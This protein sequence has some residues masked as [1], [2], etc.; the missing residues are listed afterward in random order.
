M[1]QVKTAVAV[2]NLSKK[3]KGFTLDI[4]C[5]KIPQGFATALIGENGAGK[6][7]LLNA[8]A[9]VRL[10]YKGNMEFFGQ[11]DDK[12][13]ENADCPVKEM[14]GYVGS[15]NYYLPQWTVKQVEEI[16][17]LLYQNFDCNKFENYIQQLQVATKDN[18]GKGKKVNDLSDGNRMKL[19][20]SGA[21]C[22]R[23]TDAD[24]GRTGI[25]AGSF[26]A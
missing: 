17:D 3:F 15:N 11:W 7:T 14:I 19:M 12:E 22:Q 4:P 24:S 9:G 10:D 6:T 1:E 25:P 26:D 5:L 16:T 20:L 18:K 21:F 8:L 23:D 13:R 2:N